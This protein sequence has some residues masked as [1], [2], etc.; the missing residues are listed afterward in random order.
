LVRSVERRSVVWKIA[1]HT[2]RHKPKNENRRSDRSAG[3]TAAATRL[4][5]LAD[6][7]HAG[8]AAAGAV[9]EGQ[10]LVDVVHLTHTT[11]REGE[12]ARG[13]SAA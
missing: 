11:G 12:N 9:V 13:T 6:G 2:D 7:G 1:R 3:W 8:E 4:E 10:R 5:P